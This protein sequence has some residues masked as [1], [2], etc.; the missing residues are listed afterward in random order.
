M[1]GLPCIDLPGSTG[2]IKA[3]EFKVVE[4]ICDPTALEWKFLIGAAIFAS[5]LLILFF[6]LF[7]VLFRNDKTI[8]W[9]KM[10][11]YELFSTVFI[12]IVLVSL[13]QG[14][15]SFQAGWM[16]SEFQISKMGINGLTT[17]S[18]IYRMSA[19]YFTSVSSR[20]VKWMCFDMAG[21][22]VADWGT[23]TQFM[24]R[25]MG[26]GFHTTPLAGL[27]APL[28]LILNNAM[29]AMVIT[30]VVNDAMFFI[31]KYVLIAF[32][33][34]FL[35][36]GIVFR[37][38]EPT[39]R[40]G[41]T[42]IALSIAF[43]V[44]FPILI[45][46]SFYVS[47]VGMFGFSSLEEVWDA[48]FK[49]IWDGF[50]DSFKGFLTAIINAASD[51]SISGLILGPLSKLLEVI[52]TFVLF[53]FGQFF[54]LVYFF[55]GGLVVWWVALVGFVLPAFNTIILVYSMRSLG[56]TLGEPIDITSLTRVI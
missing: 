40:F 39:R 30:Y 21:S 27:F 15:C 36:F 22:V 12:I 46:V 5:L 48:K 41:G 33:K 16:F 14:M 49:G 37:S 23:S 2:I 18:N 53:T 51:G 20:L 7:A 19:T 32:P 55:F 25:P 4:H 13:I 34:Y 35:P 38:F 45:S 56:K 44:L 50:G 26:Q 31:L 29:I 43:L 8:A 10:E 52:F 1:V 11:M 42:L 24:V 3:S 54:G 6:Y 28:K 9:V 17:S 47:E